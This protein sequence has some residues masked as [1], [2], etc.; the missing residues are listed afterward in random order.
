MLRQYGGALYLCGR[1]NT[2]KNLVKGVARDQ[3]YNRGWL[4]G[5]GLQEY[6]DQ[7]LVWVEHVDSEGGYCIQNCTSAIMS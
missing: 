3:T 5:A 6:S 1:G 7:L 2:N 4:K